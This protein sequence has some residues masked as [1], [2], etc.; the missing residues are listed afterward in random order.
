[1]RQKTQMAILGGLILFAPFVWYMNSTNPAPTAA[2][3]SAFQNYPL[4]AVEN[5]Q[6]HRSL[7]ETAQKTEYHS[8]GRNPFSAVAAPLPETRSNV[9]KGYA[10]SGAGVLPSPPPPLFSC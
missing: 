9:A 7:M 1:M 5:P 8:L 4:L 2:T 10:P 3:T 6:L